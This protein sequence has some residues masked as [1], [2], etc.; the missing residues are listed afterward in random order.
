M[1]ETSFKKMNYSDPDHQHG[2]GL[3]HQAPSV[4]TVT[5]D[6]LTFETLLVSVVAVLF[7]LTYLPQTGGLSVGSRNK[8]KKPHLPVGH[9]KRTTTSSSRGGLQQHDSDTAPRGRRTSHVGGHHNTDTAVNGPSGGQ[10]HDTVVLN[11]TN[12]RNPTS[13][14]SVKSVQGQSPQVRLSS[15]RLTDRRSVDD[16]DDD[17][18]D[19]AESSDDES[20]G[21]SSA[22]TSLDGASRGEE[23][24]LLID[25]DSEIRVGGCKTM[26]GRMH[27]EAELL[28]D[29]Q[30]ICTVWKSYHQWRKLWS[31]TGSKRHCSFLRRKFFS[32]KESKITQRRAC[33]EGFASDLRANDRNLNLVAAFF[34]CNNV[35]TNSVGRFEAVLKQGKQQ[36]KAKI[37][38][39][40]PEKLLLTADEDGEQGRKCR[41]QDRFQKI[42]RTAAT[43]RWSYPIARWMRK[44]RSTIK[45][46]A[47][48]VPSRAPSA[49]RKR[50]TATTSPRMVFSPPRLRLVAFL[51]LRTRSGSFWGS[52]TNVPAVSP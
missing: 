16:D 15:L 2:R 9:N 5:S 42:F 35:R 20:S 8:I 12:K 3:S 13:S 48:L 6:L 33:L 14:G 25:F 19:D 44:L 45:K 17:S 49:T 38:K 51:R 50:C 40:S 1:N 34:G 47:C 27:F 21:A 24:L 32:S 36:S 28:Q 41:P 11:G 46:A 39:S 26:A 7:V 30:S 10:D 52:V 37:P 29:G 18:N 22:S 23:L 4:G 31:T 43:M